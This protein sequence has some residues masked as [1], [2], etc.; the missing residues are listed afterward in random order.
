[1]FVESAQSDASMAAPFSKDIIQ[2]V[3]FHPTKPLVAVAGEMATAK[4]CCALHNS[5]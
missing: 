2:C 5:T 4:V 3:A 1:M